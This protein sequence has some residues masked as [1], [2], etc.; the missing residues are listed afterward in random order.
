MPLCPAGGRRR[1]PPPAGP[2]SSSPWSSRSPSPPSCWRCPWAATS[3]PPALPRAELPAEAFADSM[4]VV[5][6]L[7]YVD[8][9]YGRLAEVIARLR[10]LGVRHVRE[11]MPTPPVGAQANGLRAAAHPRLPGHARDRRPERPAG[12]RGRGRADG[13]ARERRRL[14]G[15]Q[16]AR[17][18]R[19]P[20]LARAAAGLHARAAAPRSATQ[21]PGVP[22]IGPS[23][24]S[25]GDRA[26][27]G[28]LPGLVNGH[29][30]PGGKPPEPVLGAAV[31][32]LGARR[33]GAR[34]VVLHRDRLPQRARR[35]SGRSR[36]CP[37][38]WRR[39]T[40]PGSTPPPSAP[41]CGGRSSTSLP[42]RCPSRG[43]AT[44]SSTSACCAPTSLR[45]PP[46]PRSRRCS[47]PCASRPG[48]RRGAG[49][50]PGRSQVDG[51]DDRDVQRLVLVRRD[52]SHVLVLWRAV[53]VWD[54]DR[55]TPLTPAPLGVRLHFDRP[56]RDVAVWRPSTSRRP[57]PARRG[58]AGAAAAARRR[59]RGRVA[60][61][62][63]RGAGPWGRRCSL[64]GVRPAAPL[65][66]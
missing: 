50:W 19:R 1:I 61:V 34:D 62:S 24:I 66:P 14:R 12:P 57:R 16:R 45:S 7:N 5:I 9:A 64:A 42:T 27:V 4:G 56:A 32:E 44:P 11:A 15:P 25:P 23:F 37:R 48:A 41:A 21:A 40:C 29:P 49:G 35:H 59:P 63:R 43:C 60:A 6:H 18:Q 31:R 47:R 39:S 22:L 10:E 2:P 54:R 13:H 28:D 20:G 33:G 36:R 30:Y 17:Q 55:R 51:G 46:S 53:S 65:R 26:R 38:P 58:D 8:T 52:G 3:A